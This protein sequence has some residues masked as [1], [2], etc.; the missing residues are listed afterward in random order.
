[1]NTFEDLFKNFVRIYIN[2]LKL[3]LSKF[4]LNVLIQKTFTL[5]KIL[6]KKF[7]NFEKFI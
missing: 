5:R 4:L 2:I 3:L 1:M 6:K 7:E